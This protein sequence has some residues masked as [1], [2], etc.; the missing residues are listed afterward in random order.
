MLKISL[1]DAYWTRLY[2]LGKKGMALFHAMAKLKQ[3]VQSKNLMSQ[4]QS[5]KWDHQI[6]KS[7]SD[8]VSTYQVSSVQLATD[9]KV[10]VFNK[11]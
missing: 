8:T 2:D 11:A 5:Q 9:K 7:A 6:V 3:I 1:I 4:I 10:E